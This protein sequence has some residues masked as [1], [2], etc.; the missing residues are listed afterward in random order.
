MTRVDRDL[1][2]VIALTLVCAIVVVLVP[3]TAMHAAFAVPLCLV[4]PGYAISTAAFTRHPLGWMF[5]L[6]L[7]PALSLAS[8]ALGAILLNIAPGGIRLASWVIFLV[9]VVLAA[10]IVTFLRRRSNATVVSGARPSLRLRGRDSILLSV[11]VLAI[12]S[13]FA[14]SR[15]PLAAKNAEGY[16]QMSMIASG[17]ARA[18]HVRIGIISA[19][20]TTARYLLTLGNGSGFRVLHKFLILKPDQ[21]T[22]LSVT[23]PRTRVP[24]AIVTARLYRA[25][26]RGLYRKATAVFRNPAAHG[27]SRHRRQT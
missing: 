6:W 1:C 8:L 2:T 18:P 13:S 20:K 7:V 26:V 9:V 16:T 10:C 21:A 11:A 22:E 3:G 12:G 4:L 24:F 5:R 14:L 15:V 27:P 17:T 23:L 19:E 25:G